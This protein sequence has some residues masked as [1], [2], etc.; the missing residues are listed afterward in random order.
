MKRAKQQLDWAV[1]SA[2]KRAKASDK[3]GE[4]LKPRSVDTPPG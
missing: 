1:E 4:A 2:S 3:R